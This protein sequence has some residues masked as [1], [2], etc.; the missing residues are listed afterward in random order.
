M[1]TKS[2]IETAVRRL[3]NAD[4]EY[5]RA[6]QTGEQPRLNKAGTAYSIAKIKLY[7]LFGF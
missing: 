7:N 2:E 3:R 1:A 5:W 4:K 6:Q